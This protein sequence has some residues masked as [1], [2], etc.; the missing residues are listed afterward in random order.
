[1]NNLSTFDIARIWV[2][3]TIEGGVYELDP[4]FEQWERRPEGPD[5]MALAGYDRGAFLSAA[6]GTANQ[7]WVNGMDFAAITNYLAARTRDLS[8][9]LAADY[10]G[11]AWE[12]LLGLSRK[13]PWEGIV[14]PTVSAFDLS[15]VPSH[16]TPP[17]SLLHTLRVRHGDIDEI[18]PFSE[19]AGKN[20]SLSFDDSWR[21]VALPSPTAP[22]HGPT[23]LVPAQ[24]TIPSNVDVWFGDVYDLPD[25]P[26]VVHDIVFT[27]KTGSTLYS[28]IIRLAGNNYTHPVGGFSFKKYRADGYDLPA[29]HALTATVTFAGTSTASRGLQVEP[30]EFSS[31]P[32]GSRRSE[33]I[34]W[35]GGV[36]HQSPVVTN[37]SHG[38]N[39]GPVAYESP[40]IATARLK[41]DGLYDVTVTNMDLVGLHA[42]QFQILTGGDPGIIGP[43]EARNI[44]IQYHAGSIADHTAAIRVQF[45]YD[46]AEYEWSGLTLSGQSRQPPAQLWVDGQLL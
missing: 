34:V 22:T 36:V 45:V 7:D 42:H 39:F 43:G 28:M 27:N 10:T 12:E 3:A 18:F 21:G 44:S 6:G 2:S 20:V 14:L 1:T 38:I 46:G 25:S 40:S 5:L 19:L 24:S 4:A 17:Q 9:A 35:V 30:L 13:Q 31:Y 23:L 15:Q 8:D 32:N 33:K 11:V 16:A 41:N 37:D 26:S 29:N